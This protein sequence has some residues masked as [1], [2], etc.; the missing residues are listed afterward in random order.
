MNKTIPLSRQYEA[1]GTAFNAIELR[2]PKH[3]E[4]FA[5]GDP[6]EVQPSGAD[7]G[8]IVVEYLDRIEA[9]RDRLLVKPSL[10]EIFDLDLVDSMTLKET[11]I[12]FFT[13]A[14]R[15]RRA[16]TNSSGAADEGSTKSET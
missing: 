10:A 12:G 6:V 7:G 4:H 9:Y 13:E 14:R 15:L 11:I 3:R 1:H 16:R 5:I 2:L 8:S